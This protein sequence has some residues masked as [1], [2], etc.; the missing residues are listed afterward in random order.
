MQ[1]FILAVCA[2][3]YTRAIDAQGAKKSAK[4]AAKGSAGKMDRVY[5]V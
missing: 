3:L 4:P 5:C 2:S 1:W